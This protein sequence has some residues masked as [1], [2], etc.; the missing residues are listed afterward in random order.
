MNQPKEK[1]GDWRLRM[2][3]ID[4]QI[5]ELIIARHDIA[6]KIGDIRRASGLDMVDP[7]YEQQVLRSLES[8]AGTVL[9]PQAVRSIY[10]EI[11]S[12]ARSVLEPMKAAYLGPEA[13]FSHQAALAFFGRSAQLS[14]TETIEDVF[15]LVEKGVCCLGIVPIENS[16]EGSVNITLDLFYKY[17]LKISAEFFLRIRNHL[18]TRAS[19]MAGIKKIVSHPMPIAQCRSWIRSHLPG[20]SIME[21][22]STSMA[23]KMA[24][25]DPETAAIGSRLSAEAYGL[26]IL[27]EGIEDQPYNVTR[28]LIIGKTEARPTGDDKTSILFFLP[29]VPGSLHKALGTLAVKEVNMTH[30]QSRPMRMR[31]WEYLFFVDVE[32]H[33]TDVKV[34]EA[35][36][37][38]E[39]RCIFMKR[40]GSYPSGGA[41]WD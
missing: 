26:D 36:M 23:A 37:A 27:E 4:E 14:P 2:N 9:N 34:K 21:V 8:K 6:K 15:S 16:F 24:A 28:F 31:N 13:T 7:A 35:L 18:L 10:S 19:S 29:H 25:E 41:P 38:M 33:E 17:D 12:A 5:L 11:I 39:E 3:E 1:E 40:L 20:A 32:G 22:S 30:I